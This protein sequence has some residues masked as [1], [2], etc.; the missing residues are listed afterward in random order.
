[1]PEQKQ[2]LPSTPR[3]E[4]KLA[5]PDIALI[6]DLLV[7][8]RRMHE[9]Y[10]T[11]IPKHKA[12]KPADHKTR[13]TAAKVYGGLGR[14]LSASVG[15]LH[16]RPIALEGNWDGDMKDHAENIDGLGT[17]LSVY[18]KRRSEDAIADGFVGILVDHPSAPAGVVVTAANEK[19]LNLRPKWASYA[20]ADILSWIKIGRAHV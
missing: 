4:Y 11:Y 12:E 20:R 19:E 13:A 10:K 8:T 14:T 16:A 9:V 1:M 5:A 7:G 18:A 3:A 2:Q 17:K 6:R 15:M